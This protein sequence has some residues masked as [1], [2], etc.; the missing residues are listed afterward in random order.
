MRTWLTPAKHGMALVSIVIP[1]LR[2][3][4]LLLR[5]LESAFRQT[6]HPIEVIV[7]VDP[8]D[9]ETLDALH[10]VEDPRLRVVVTATSVSAAGARNEAASYARGE[11]I[12][13]LDDDDEWLPCKLEKQMTLAAGREAVLVTCLS[14]VVTEISTAILPEIVYVNSAPVD[15]YLFDRRSPFGGLSLLQTSSFLLSRAL[16]E[17]ITF[18]A[19]SEHDDWEFVIR[20]SKQL[21]ASIETVSEVLVTLNHP[22]GGTGGDGTWR[23]RLT[24]IDRMRPLI[25]RRAYS[26]FCLGPAAALAAKN[27]SGEGFVVLFHRAF[28]YGSPRLWQLVNFIL[29]WAL[30]S[31]SRQKLRALLCYQR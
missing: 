4:Q 17:K 20:L 5:A 2:R 10:I 26:A 14:K 19:N 28:K 31:T 15:E 1:T 6:Y 25:T 29:Y 16:F 13:F 30:P 21:G 27:R 3:P 7:A 23:A 18:N 9:K 11:W 8:H 12:A 24:W 22:G